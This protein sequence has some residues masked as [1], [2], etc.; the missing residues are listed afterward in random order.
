[1]C[2][3]VAIFILLKTLGA[4][5]PEALEINDSFQVTDYYMEEV[6]FVACKFL[7]LFVH[8]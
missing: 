2:I 7:L 4:F 6:K 1:M 5:Q 3:Y 8:V